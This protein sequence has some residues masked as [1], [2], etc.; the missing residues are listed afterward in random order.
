MNDKIIQFLDEA[1]YDGSPSE[2]AALQLLRYFEQEYDVNLLP[3]LEQEWVDEQLE[4]EL[5][6]EH[7]DTIREFI[8]E[9]HLREY[10]AALSRIEAY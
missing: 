6:D 2:P 4:R 9:Q 7:F 10:D 8:D 5:T 3:L 1:G